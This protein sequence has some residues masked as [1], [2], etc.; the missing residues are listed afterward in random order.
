MTYSRDQI[1]A[2]LHGAEDMHIIHA[3]EREHRT[4]VRQGQKHL[5]EMRQLFT[6]AE[7]KGALD[8]KTPKPK[9]YQAA[10]LIFCMTL[11]CAFIADRSFARQD[12]ATQEYSGANVPGS[13]FFDFTPPED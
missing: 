4:G 13:F 11:L 3:T 12:E 9:F 5:N 2:Y 8:L 7:L 10:A 6:K 1:E